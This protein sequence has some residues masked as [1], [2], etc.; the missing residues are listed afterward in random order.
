MAAWIGAAFGT[1]ASLIECVAGK[2]GYPPKSANFSLGLRSKFWLRKCGQ[3]TSTVST[4]NTNKQQLLVCVDNTCWR[5]TWLST[6]NGQ[7]STV[8]HTQ[9]PALDT[10]RRAFGIDVAHLLVCGNVTSAGWQVIL[11]D[12]IWH[13]SSRSGVVLVAQT[14]IRFLTYL[15]HITQRRPVQV[16]TYFDSYSLWH[17]TSQYICRNFKNCA[18]LI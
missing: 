10:V 7:L 1:R 14:A 6:V 11:C 13:V 4:C 9:H 2:S 8:D 16:T 18:K 3:S 15:Q 5:W 17:Y 12:P